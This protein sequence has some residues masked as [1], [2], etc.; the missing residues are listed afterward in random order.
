MIRRSG[1]Y[2]FDVKENMRG[3]KGSVKI[4]HYWHPGTEM[5]AN[6]RLFAKLTL[7]PG[8][9]IGFHKHDGEE[10]VFVVLRGSAEAD[11]NGH[12]TVLNTGDTILT[13]DGSGHSI[14]CISQEPL[15]LIAV[16]S[17]YK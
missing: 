4:E 14:K 5:K 8:G 16:I 15:E 10:E 7:Q 3:G 9:S 13:G 11:D 1:K 2:A 6:N 17:C 12:K